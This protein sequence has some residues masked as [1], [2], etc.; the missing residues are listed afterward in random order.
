SAA[1]TTVSRRKREQQNESLQAAITELINHFSHRNLDA[2]VR[3]IKMTLEKLRKRITSTL[4]YAGNH[5][6]APVF[7][8][9]AEL[10]IPIVTIQPP[11][12]EVQILLS[13]AVQ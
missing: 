3:V 2:I 7:K 1:L 4:T 10:A 13:K 6:E 12:D 8:V 11:T 9:F 5:H